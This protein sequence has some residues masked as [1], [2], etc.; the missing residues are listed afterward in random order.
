[1]D[2][3]GFKD[4]EDKIASNFLKQKCVIPNIFYCWEGEIVAMEES[5]HPKFNEF[6]QR[7][8]GEL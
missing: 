6:H 7:A 1:V 5:D 4:K 3:Y 8:S 2:I